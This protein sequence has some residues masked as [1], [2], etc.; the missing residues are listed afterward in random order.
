MNGGR[1]V[2]GSSPAGMVDW[3]VREI[4]GRNPIQAAYRPGLE[5]ISFVILSCSRPHFSFDRW[6]RE[7]VFRLV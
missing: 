5:R 6:Q 1:P 4:T 2:S 7:P 3:C